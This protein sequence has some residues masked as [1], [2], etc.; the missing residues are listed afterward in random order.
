[1][2]TACPVNWIWSAARVAVT[3]SS[4]YGPRFWLDEDLTLR[5]YGLGELHED[6]Q[7]ETL[8]YW[9]TRVELEAEMAKL[10]AST[11]EKCLRR[12]NP[13]NWGLS[14]VYRLFWYTPLGRVLKEVEIPLFFVHFYEVQE[15]LTRL[16]EANSTPSTRAA[17]SATLRCSILGCAPTDDPGAWPMTNVMWAST[18][19]IEALR[20]D[21]L[22]AQE[23]LMG[24]Q[25][26]ARYLQTYLHARTTYAA[27]LERLHGD[28]TSYF[29]C[30]PRDIIT[31]VIRPYLNPW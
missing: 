10:E 29:R 4:G 6:S 7:R 24:P 3:T 20:A 2:Y 30:L 15:L 25:R 14:P 12:Q 23:V 31:Y 9:S 11:S 8:C 18:L 27:Q 5:A 22:R 1:M 26:T 17:C 21:P 13:L 19:S 16:I 28:A